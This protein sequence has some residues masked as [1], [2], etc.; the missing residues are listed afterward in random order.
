V[1][2]QCRSSDHSAKQKPPASRLV[3]SQSV[4]EIEAQIAM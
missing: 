3:A 4:Y 1:L 2:S